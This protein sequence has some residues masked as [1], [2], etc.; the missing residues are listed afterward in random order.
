MV[1]VGLATGCFYDGS[2]PNIG[3]S[4]TKIYELGFDAIE[5][6]LINVD[7]LSQSLHQ[8]HLEMLSTFKFRSIHAPCTRYAETAQ[9]QKLLEKLHAVYTGTDSN[10]IVFHPNCVN[11]SQPIRAHDWNFCYENLP[12][13]KRFDL[14]K[15]KWLFKKKAPD[16]GMVLDTAHAQ[17]YN[18]FDS[19]FKN[20]KKRI[21]YVHLSV[22]S[23]KYEH[24]PLHKAKKTKIAKLK[25]IKNLGVP[26]IIE[27]WKPT[28]EDIAR[29]LDFVR[30]FLS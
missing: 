30:E 8:E 15:M 4:I 18:Q 28:L 25:K 26:V 19:F 21:K 10:Y 24:K 11:S 2:S 13:N 6:S 5:L 27:L 16:F 1:T 22:G 9:T 29:E 7:S 23:P 3:D 12:A 20:F 17:T 14:W